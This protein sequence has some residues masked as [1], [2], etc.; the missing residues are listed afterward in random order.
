MKHHSAALLARYTFLRDHPALAQCDFE[1]GKIN[2]EYIDLQEWSPTQ[3]IIIEVLRFL[4]TGT[5]NVQLEDLN[6]LTD[7]ERNAVVMALTDRYNMASLEE[8]LAR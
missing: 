1:L 6:Y 7:V 5:A 4:V 2:W 3:L 8:N